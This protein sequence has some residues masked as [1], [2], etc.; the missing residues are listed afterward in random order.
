M[1]KTKIKKDKIKANCDYKNH[2]TKQYSSGATKAKY[3]SNDSNKV[4]Y[5]IG[6]LLVL[7][8]LTSKEKKLQI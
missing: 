8:F 3:E 1:D 6:G 2:K 7:L 5:L 4:M